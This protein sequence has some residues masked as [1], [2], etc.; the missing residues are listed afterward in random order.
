MSKNGI[1]PNMTSFTVALAGL[2]RD[3]RL[4]LVDK[5]LSLMKKH[6]CHPRLS[7]YNVRVQELCKLGRVVEAEELLKEMKPNWE[8]YHHLI[9]GFCSVNDLDEAKRVYEE[10]RRRGLVPES[11]CYFTL[12]HYLCKGGDFE[13]ALGVCKESMG[14]NWVPCFSTMRRLVDG[15]VSIS[16]AGEAREIVAK[17]KEKF[18]SSAHLWKEIE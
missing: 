12:I 15:L 4:D 16:M 3:Q 5:L 17:V 7:V 10:M 6:N 18:P 2:Y 1:K 11:S 8:T 14:R 13:F 9:L